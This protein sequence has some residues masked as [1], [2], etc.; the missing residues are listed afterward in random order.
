MKKVWYDR[1]LLLL[2]LPPACPPPPYYIYIYIDASVVA[3]VTH[4]GF[5]IYV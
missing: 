3:R 4:E 2:L 1:L 5:D